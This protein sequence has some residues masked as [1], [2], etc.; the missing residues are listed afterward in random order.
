VLHVVLKKPKTV[1]TA[2]KEK[3]ATVERKEVLLKPITTKKL[4]MTTLVQL[5]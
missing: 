4:K 3:K 5:M 2:K 1:T